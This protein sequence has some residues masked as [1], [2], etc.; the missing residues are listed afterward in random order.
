M[1][2]QDNIDAAKQKMVELNAVSPTMCLAKWLQ[3]TT[4][5]YN[6]MTHSCHHPSQ[7]KINIDNLTRNPAGLHNTPEKLIARDDMLNGIQTQ[8]CDY[9]WR[10]ENLTYQDTMSDRTYKSSSPWAW[11]HLQDVL[12][13]GVGAEINPTYFEV[14]FE[15]TCNFKCV[16][17]I[18]EVSS[19]WL[20]EVKTHGAYQLSNKKVHDPEYILNSNR[21]PIHYKEYNPYIDA[22]WEWWPTLYPSLDT[23]R[24]TGGEPLL[25][26][27][28][29]NVLDYILLH[30]R[31]ELTL[32]I[33]TNM[34]VPQHLVAKLIDYCNR[35]SPHIKE[36]QIFTSAEATGPQCE[37]IRYGMVWDEFK[38]NC[39]DF[40]TRTDSRVKLSFMVTAN[41]LGATTFTSF[42]EWI[43]LLRVKHNL[44]SAFNRVP[45]M[46]AYLR[47]PNHLAVTNLPNN[48]K[49]MY[50]V[51]WKEYV[52]RYNVVGSPG[53]FY[54]EEVDQVTRLINFMNSTAGTEEQ[55]ADFYKFQSEYDRRRETNVL[56][57]FPELGEYY[58]YGKYLSERTDV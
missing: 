35:L 9:C 1:S 54:L 14:A 53:R 11:P 36:I 8:E 51:E 45:I 52:D 13:S 49:E 6:G 7:H 27:H 38:Q 23:F 16:Y 4:T 19:R 22:F 25:S 39:D 56:I 30:P 33:N 21:L 44:T 20:E 42:L 2:N 18:P 34:G 55:A 12:D 40:L 48:L 57:E 17:C 41:L 3:S 37:Y 26:D 47:W 24:I 29:W 58:N 5:L 31:K 15:H 10:I 32:A 50:S 28:T 43:L 46:V